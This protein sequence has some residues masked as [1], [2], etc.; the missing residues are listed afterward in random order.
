MKVNQLK[1]GAFLSYFSLL[2]SNVITLLYT[3][4]MMNTM[5]QSQYGLYAAVFN[6]AGFLGI[7]DFGF[8]NAIVRYTVSFKSQGRIDKVYSLFGM[9]LILYSLIGLLAFGAGLGLYFNVTSFFEKS[10]TLQE[11]EE[12]RIMIFLMILNVAVSF[13]LGVFGSIIM[14]YENFVFQKV[15]NIIRIVL[16]PCIMIPLLLMGYKAVAMVVVFTVLNIFCLFLNCWYCFFRLHI[17]FYFKKLEWGLTREIVNYSF[18]VF[19]GIIV[20]KIYWGSGNFV[21][22]SIAGATVAAVY[23]I[24]MQLT[25]YYMNFSLAVSGVFLPKLTKMVTQKQSDSEISDLF[26][27]LGRIQYLVMALILS[28]FVLFGKS[29]IYL[30]VGP[31]FKDAYLIGLII[32]IPLTIPL[33][34]NLG[35]TILQARNQQKF[36]SLVYIVIALLSLA[37]SIPLAKEYGGVGYALGTSFA[38]IVGNIFV[39]NIYYYKKIHLNIPFFW[40]EIIRMTFPIVLVAI[41]S[42]FLSNLYGEDNWFSLGVKILLY[43]LSYGIVVWKFVMNPYERNLFW[44]PVQKVFYRYRRS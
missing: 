24:V 3:P 26:V 28:G 32:L 36:R 22:A 44:S 20:D 27:K 5:G 12:A 42:A 14:S 37:I 35:I 9:F 33:I 30:W 31:G 13:P 19:I 41:V 39:M 18:F 40:K 1:A 11:I 38:L 10:L 8:G 15:V 21:M 43:I 2:L 7:L 23:A 34:Q 25:N 4:F 6:V 17:R 29:F 16:Q